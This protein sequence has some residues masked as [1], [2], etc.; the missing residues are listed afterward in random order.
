[1][2]AY[3]HIGGYQYLL[4]VVTTAAQ[5][6]SLRKLRRA[7]AGSCIRIR[8]TSDNAEQDIGFVNNVVDT[9]AITAFVG[10]NSAHIVR[11]YDQS[12]NGFDFIQGTVALQP[13]IVNGG[14]MY[15]V[16]GLPTVWFLRDVARRLN[17]AAA[18]TYYN[19]I[20]N[21]T[22]TSIMM[23]AQ[24]GIVANP[25][26]FYLFLDNGYIDAS[27]TITLG[28]FYDDRAAVPRNNM[29]VTDM[30]QYSAPFGYVAR[31]LVDNTILPNQQN[32]L[33]NF[34]DTNEATAANRVKGY[35]N[36]G[37]VFNA[38]VQT[39]IASVNP[40][41]L[42]FMGATGIGAVGALV[43]GVQECVFWFSDKSAQLADI[44]DITNGYYNTY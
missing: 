20:F 30:Y 26:D 19:P 13:Y 11:W 40:S 42:M 22:P 12:G 43:G 44:K 28:L 3:I 10:I 34:I 17:S 25:N 9:A 41:Q 6:V 27:G 16:N 8:R 1:M 31:N 15:M 4:D 21:G 33:I 36:N 7:Y 2:P 24:A 14:A 29:L 39:K 38:N 37:A 18:A 5:A 23:V 32:I 35:V